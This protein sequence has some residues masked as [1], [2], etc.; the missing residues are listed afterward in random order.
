MD[1]CIWF[2]QACVIKGLK[3]NKEVFPNELIGFR[4]YN[5]E[6]LNDMIKKAGKQFNLMREASEQ[7]TKEQARL[8]SIEI[9]RPL[10]DQ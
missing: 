9:K 8:E 6:R 7:Q 3:K 5:E 2:C 4:R 10:S 1:K